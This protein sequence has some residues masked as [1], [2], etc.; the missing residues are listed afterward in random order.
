MKADAQAIKLFA[1]LTGCLFVVFN[2]PGRLVVDGTTKSW[3]ATS[4]PEP[5]RFADM[6]RWPKPARARLI[7][8]WPWVFHS[9]TGY[10]FITKEGRN[11]LLPEPDRPSFWQRTAIPLVA[12]DLAVSAFL[13]I[14]LQ[15]A[16]RAFHRN[17]SRNVFIDDG[18]ETR[19]N[20]A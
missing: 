17:D 3:F 13:A 12:A 5:E 11:L 15:L 20:P 18:T 19:Q 6:I 1:A 2:L 14:I 7:R 10:H 16:F 4:V 9:E 8:G